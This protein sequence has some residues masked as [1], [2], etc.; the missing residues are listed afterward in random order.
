[1]LVIAWSF[2]L[3]FQ[4]CIGDSLEDCQDPYIEDIA[5]TLR[6]YFDYE[7]SST[8]SNS[9]DSLAIERGVRQLNMEAVSQVDL[10]VFNAETGL[11]VDKYTDLQPR[12]M[13]KS[14][15]YMSLSLLP[16]RYRF[17]AWGGLQRSDFAVAPVTPVKQG[18]HFNDFSV[19]Y[20][21]QG[22]TVTAGIGNLYYGILNDVE[23][24]IP[25]RAAA[26]Y[27]SLRINIRQDTY[28]FNIRL[29]GT[30]VTRQFGSNT[31][32]TDDV[33]EAVIVDNN[34]FYNFNNRPVGAPT[35]CYKSSFVP[36][37]DLAPE[38][39]TSRTT[40]LVD[41]DRRPVLK[42][43]RNGQPWQINEMEEGIDLVRVLQNYAS[44]RLKLDFSVMYVFNIKFTING[45]PNDA[46]SLAV[47]LDIGDWHHAIKDS[48]LFM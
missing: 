35:Y 38:W 20:L 28:T 10:Y 25:S 3:A 2:G 36:G 15:Y 31:E 13:Q 39:N 43:Y 34:S 30:A 12:L 14:I 16:G 26:D 48:E 46:S 6:V 33:F 32:L 21:F 41:E 22:D 11:F 40:L 1:M 17:V 47:S 23:V 5:R 42:F 37:N 18:S 27:D 44:G 24:A 8:V 7:E 45:N 19:N 9:A 4:S 29:A